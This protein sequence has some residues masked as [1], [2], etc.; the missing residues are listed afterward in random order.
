MPYE[1][2]SIDLGIKNSF[3]TEGLIRSVQ[4]FIIAVLGCT[5]FCRS[6]IWLKV[7]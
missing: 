6:K 2:G 3:K 4:G 1:Y 7:D 5:A